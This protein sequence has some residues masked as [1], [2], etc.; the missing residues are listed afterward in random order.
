MVQLR[1]WTS[2][3]LNEDLFSEKWAMRGTH[4]ARESPRK[5]QE[6]EAITIA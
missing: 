2:K 3:Y 4:E 1:E 6:Q 5:W